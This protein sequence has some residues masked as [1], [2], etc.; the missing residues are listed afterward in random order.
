MLAKLALSSL[1]ALGAISMAAPAAAQA[2][3]CSNYYRCIAACPFVGDDLDPQC[4]A[5]C[6]TLQ[7]FGVIC[8]KPGAKPK[9]PVAW[10]PH[11]AKAYMTPIPAGAVAAKVLAVHAASTPGA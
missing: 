8:R 5:Y 4:V 6:D 2:E 10:V 1:F 9:H 11:K 3:P 7:P